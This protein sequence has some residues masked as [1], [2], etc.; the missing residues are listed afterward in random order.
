MSRV[1]VNGIEYHFEEA[2]HGP[3]LLLLHGFTGSGQ[4][5]EPL[6]PYLTPHYRVITPDL[7]GHGSTASPSD[8]ARYSIENTVAD[9][10]AILDALKIDR[11]AILGYSMGGRLALYFA[12]HYPQRVTALVLES[13]SPG[14][15]TAQGR[16]E[17][18]KA[19][20]AL[21]DFIEVKGLAA[22]VER[23]EKLPLWANQTAEMRAKLH[24]QRLQNRPG[25]LANSLRGLGTGVQPSLWNKLPE[26]KGQTLL[27]SGELD[28]KFTA[29]AGQM[30]EKLPDA[31]LEVVPGAGHT[32][33]L[34]QPER[35]VEIVKGFL[36]ANRW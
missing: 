5:W 34:E 17:R 21:A 22:F 16:L 18:Q 29:I 12:L 30:R 1:E 23:W 3:A 13:A 28:A 31:R 36:C 6:L 4:N 8:P 25:G 11:A 35:Y 24:R 20:D 19:D 33:H 7:P 9:L 10:A 15:A 32:V 14:L 2:G 27:I 26:F